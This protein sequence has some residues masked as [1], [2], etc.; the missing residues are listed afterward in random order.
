MRLALKGGAG[1]WEAFG[2]AMPERILNGWLEYFN[3]EPFGDDQWF[4][5]LSNAF[6]MLARSFHNE[7]YA[8][9]LQKSDFAPWRKERELSEAEEAQLDLPD[10]QLVRQLDRLQMAA[11]GKPV[12]R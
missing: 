2:D 10:E 12:Q 8:F 7:D 5:F 11:T 3:R 6:V 1:D 4:D 9:E